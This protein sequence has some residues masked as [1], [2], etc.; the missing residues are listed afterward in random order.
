MSSDSTLNAA[1][2]LSVILG[3]DYPNG[4]S[5]VGCDADKMELTFMLGNVGAWRTVPITA[6]QLRALQDNGLI[7]EDFGVHLGGSD[8]M[9]SAQQ[10]H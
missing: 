1:A 2:K 6:V 3:D 9:P 7:D 8:A 5:W 10:L 4:A